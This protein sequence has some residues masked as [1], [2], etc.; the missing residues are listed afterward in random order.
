MQTDYIWIF[1]KNRIINGRMSGTILVS[2]VSIKKLW[3]L[4][5]MNPKVL[6]F[7]LDSPCYGLETDGDEIIRY[8][9][10]N[11]LSAPCSR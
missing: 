11:S 10:P 4:D 8:L 9:I 5:L 3:Q 7:G 6:Y 2:F 1:D